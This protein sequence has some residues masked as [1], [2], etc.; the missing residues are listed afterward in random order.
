MGLFQVD[1]A[2]DNHTLR[3]NSLI[4]GAHFITHVTHNPFNQDAK[5][6]T[7]EELPAAAHFNNTVEFVI[8]KFGPQSYDKMTGEI[9]V[10]TSWRG[11]DEAE[12][13]I[14]SIYEKWID[15]P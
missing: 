1:K 8:N 10:L 5:L 11:F 4:N 15:V 13:A 9:C 6:Q 12:K 3:V 14:Q 2:F 7:A